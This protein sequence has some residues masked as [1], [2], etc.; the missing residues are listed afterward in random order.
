MRSFDPISLRLFIAVCEECNIAS[1]ARREG[2]VPSAV[3]KRVAQ[4]EAETGVIRKFECNDG[5]SGQP[6]RQ[7]LFSATQSM[8]ANSRGYDAAQISAAGKEPVGSYS[9]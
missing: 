9:A 4:M 6:D 1:A 3:G 2:L 7:R 8:W 5:S